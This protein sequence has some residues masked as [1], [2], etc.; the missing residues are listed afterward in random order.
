M[1]SQQ[2]GSANLSRFRCMKGAQ[3]YYSNVKQI[4]YS[5]EGMFFTFSLWTWSFSQ[6]NGSI[7][8]LFVCMS[9]EDTQ[10]VV[11]IHLPSAPHTHTHARARTHTHARTRTR[12]RTHTHTHTHNWPTNYTEQDPFWEA[13]SSQASQET[14]NILRNLKVHYCVHTSHPSVPVLSHIH[15][16]NT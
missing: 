7:I 14:C 8:K 4:S 13:E 10:R 12:T 3:Q 5:E 16:V 6:I 1:L 2:T 11:L 9:C 15:P